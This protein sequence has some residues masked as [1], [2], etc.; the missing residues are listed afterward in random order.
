MPGTKRLVRCPQCGHDLA[1]LAKE[2][3]S[4]RAQLAQYQRA[5]T[6]VPQGVTSTVYVASPKR[7]LFHRSDCKW[8]ENIPVR[9]RLTFAS[10]KD[11]VRAGKR[12]CKTCAS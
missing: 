8:A 5:V 4:L 9:G 6:V 2:I 11:A 10:H 12:P 1:D 7:P 3:D